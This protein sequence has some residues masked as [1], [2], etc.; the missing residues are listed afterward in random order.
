MIVLRIYHLP[1]RS[2]LFFTSRYFISYVFKNPR[3]IFIDRQVIIAVLYI[4]DISVID[5]ITGGNNRAIE[6]GRNSCIS[7]A[8]Y[9]DTE[10]SFFGVIG[11]DYF[12]F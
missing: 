11:F 7:G 1:T 8:L 12:A 3:I 2:R 4:Y 9:V 5:C 6:D 10:M